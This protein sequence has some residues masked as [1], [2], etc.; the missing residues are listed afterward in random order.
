MKYETAGRGWYG[1]YSANGVLGTSPEEV[2]DKLGLPRTTE[3]LIHP[4]ED[5][6]SVRARRR[7]QQLRMLNSPSRLR[8][9]DDNF[10]SDF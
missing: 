3:Y 8:E 10:I 4:L 5:K 9:R 1:Q 6:K 2:L 7:E